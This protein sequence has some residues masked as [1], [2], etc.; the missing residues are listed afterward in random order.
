MEAAVVCIDMSWITV[1]KPCTQCG[2][3]CTNADFMERIGISAPDVARW[4]SQGRTDILAMLNDVSGWRDPG[5]CPFLVAD[6]P[7]RYNCS[8]YETR[9]QT[10]REYPI[11]VDHMRVVNCE[12]LEP[13]DTDQ[14]IAE[15]MGR[16]AEAA[17]PEKIKQ[18]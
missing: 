5:P 11:A 13:N 3:C 12:M 9:P 15:F 10:C 6:G 4:K 14:H 2:R 18:G 16:P 1:T 17:S 8:I 7:N